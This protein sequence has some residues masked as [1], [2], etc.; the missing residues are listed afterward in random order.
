VNAAL[1][2]AWGDAAG[3]AVIRVN[4][5]DFQVREELGFDL[6]GQ[7]EHVFLYLEKSR[8]TT[9]ELL[10]R[11]ARLG[12]VSQREVG[13]SGLKDRN[14]LTSQWFS[15]GL[16]GRPEPDWQQLESGGDVTVLRVGRHQRKLKRGVHR[17][18][19]FSLR[20]RQLEGER[21]RLQERLQCIRR[22]GVPNYFGE[23]RFGRDAS[24]LRQAE[25]WMQGGGAR[26]TR[27]KRS[28]YLSA[29]RSKIYNGLLAERVGGGSWNQV[30][31][32][33]VCILQGT[34]SHFRCDRVDAD[35]AARTAA[36]DLH[37]AL[38]LW[39]RGDLNAPDAE[40]A[41]CRFLEEAGLELAWRATRVVPDDFCWRF[42]DDDGLQ[43]DF[44]LGAGSYATA[45]LAELVQYREE[46]NT[47]S[48]KGSE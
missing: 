38:P 15:V 4:P 5:A 40:R 1:P 11:V 43:L 34:R 2:R 45:L 10:D 44:A 24:T 3:S 27:N 13:V 25:R 6:T 26:T 33:D 23:Q 32:G 42:C 16:A 12:G 22:E 36:L 35:I 29:L 48:D 31:D 7:G 41:T 19:R 46:R 14:A 37:P 39:G 8:L 28:L 18:N 21:D 20:L 30:L 47:G 17:A 9:M